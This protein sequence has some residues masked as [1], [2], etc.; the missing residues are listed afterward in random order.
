MATKSL[1]LSQRVERLED[2]TKDYHD[3]EEAMIEQ[4]KAAIIHLADFKQMI[5]KLMD[6]VD[7]VDDLNMKCTK[8]ITIMKGISELV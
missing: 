8:L 3:R 2:L 7:V 4:A 5:A 1:T 6:M